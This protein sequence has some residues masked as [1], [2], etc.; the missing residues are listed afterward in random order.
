MKVGDKLPLNR[1]DWYQKN[2]DND[3]MI[4]CKVEE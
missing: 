1:F 3:D 4:E 2:K